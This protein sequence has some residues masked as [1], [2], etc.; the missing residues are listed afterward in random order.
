M[1][2]QEECNQILKQEQ[3]NHSTR[4]GLYINH[5]VAVNGANPAYTRNYILLLAAVPKS[6]MPERIVGMVV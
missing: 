3:R 1:K 4:T 2:A 6:H 5:T